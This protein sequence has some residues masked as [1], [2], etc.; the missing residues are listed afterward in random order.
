MPAVSRRK[1]CL[2]MW[3]VLLT[4]GLASAGCHTLPG[5]KACFDCP[6]PREKD[7]VSLPAYVIEPPDVLLIDAVRLIPKPPYKVEPLDVLIIQATPALPDAPISG[8]YLV[9]PDGTVNL[10]APYGIVRVIGM[11]LEEAQKVI[12]RH[13]D[14]K[15]IKK[16]EV[17]VSLGQS[18]GLQQVRGEHLVR[19][20][21]TVSL[22]AYGDVYVAGRTLPDTKLLIEAHLSQF[23]EK[24]EVTVDIFGYNS[25]VYYVITDGAGY[26]GEQVYRLPVTGNET[27]LDALAH[28]GGLTPVSSKKR[29]WLA[30][31]GP[32]TLCCEQILPV[33][34]K[35]ITQGARTATNYQVLPGD[36]IY[37]HSAPLINLDAAIS[38]VVTPIERLF[39]ITLLGAGAIQQ[40]QA[41]SGGG[42]GAG[43]TFFP[44]I[45]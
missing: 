42:G 37:V 10:G 30:R 41:A 33:D 27:V 16:P 29:I 24:P 5:R 22:G 15:Y 36:R 31:P 23:L 28:V 7:M 3:A 34:W 20:D 43:G 44:I 32:A 35:G 2:I 14:L 4:L 6:G 45:P 25:K 26:S 9:E 12:Y 38:R 40:V 19:P 13:L 39:G 1:P 21:G 17:I 18:R 11:T 8:P